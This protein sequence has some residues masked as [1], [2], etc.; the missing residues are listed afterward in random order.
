[1]R[2]GSQ[3]VGGFSALRSRSSF[4]TAA[5]KASWSFHR[6]KPPKRR[7][8]RT[9][10]GIAQHRV[11]EPNR[12]EG[13]LA[14][15]LLPIHHRFNLVLEFLARDGVFREHNQNLVVVTNR[16]V[17]LRAKAIDGLKG[18]RTRTRPASSSELPVIERLPESCHS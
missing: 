10:A 18:L 3:T 5:S 15:A 11:A 6:V 12:E 14:G 4:A 8:L 17:D 1:M 16:L 2:E 13:R 9:S 7:V